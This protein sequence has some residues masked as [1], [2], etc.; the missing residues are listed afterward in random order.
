[1]YI[2]GTYHTAVRRALSQEAPMLARASVPYLCDQTSSVSYI[3]I[4]KKMAR[5]IRVKLLLHDSYL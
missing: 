5:R 1:M 2:P 3:Q 4:L